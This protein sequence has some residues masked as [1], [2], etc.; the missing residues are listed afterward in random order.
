MKSSDSWMHRNASRASIKHRGMESEMT[1]WCFVKYQCTMSLRWTSPPLCLKLL[2]VRMTSRPLMVPI[3]QTW[4][5]SDLAKESVSNRYT[6]WHQSEL[7]NTLI[8]YKINQF[9]AVISQT[10]I[11]SLF[12]PKR[13]KCN[14]A[15]LHA[16]H[17]AGRRLSAMPISDV[18][19]RN[20]LKPTHKMLRSAKLL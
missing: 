12:E 10:Q 13:V 18:T 19:F 16:E 8:V 15:A 5:L 6:F 14:N 20:K 2:P 1:T 17:T 9:H 7:F 3:H 4:G 11:L